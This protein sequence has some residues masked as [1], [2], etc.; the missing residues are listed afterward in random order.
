MKNCLLLLLLLAPLLHA[1]ETS[2]KPGI[3]QRF[4]DPGLEVVD[5][6]KRFEIE[7]REVYAARNEILRACEINPGMHIADI[8]AGTGLYTDLFSQATGKD[9]WVYAV[10]ISARFLEHINQRSQSNTTRNVS[11]I[12]C[13]EDH[14]GIP[15]N[16]VDRVFIC[17]TY[18][19]FEY[20]ASTMA[21]I[22][23]AMKPGAQLLLLDFHRIEGVSREWTMGHV[24]AGKEVFKQEII[25]AGLVFSESV[26]IEQLKDN[27]CLRF[28]KPLS[29]K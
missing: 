27:Y 11:A 10:D 4:L 18:H 8:G 19:H 28:I 1:Q 16:S 15:P 3:N 9:G 24:R 12:L 13:A 21:S 17:D 5:W 26:G 14:V 23:Q 6:L 20:P 22:I 25:D 2:V 7:S 29:A